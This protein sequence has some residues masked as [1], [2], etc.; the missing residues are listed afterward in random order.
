MGAVWE[1]AVRRLVAAWASEACHRVATDGERTRHWEDS[2]DDATAR[3]LTADALVFAERAIVFAAKH[4]RAY[5]LA[6]RPA[7][8]AR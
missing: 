1:Y 7:P 3:W 2:D 6:A 4:K 8:Q 5:H